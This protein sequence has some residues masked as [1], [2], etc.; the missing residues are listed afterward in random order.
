M[1]ARWPG[2][3]EPGTETNHV[4]ANWDFFPTA[5]E[6][7]GLPVSGGLDGISYLSTLTGKRQQAHDYLYWEYERRGKTHQAIRMGDWKGIRFG[8]TESLEL[9]D[10]SGDSAETANMASDQADIVGKIEVLMESARTES[11]FWELL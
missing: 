6:I 8:A 9:Y 4:C 2:K 5:L 3:I 10:L 7:A 1:I 11:E